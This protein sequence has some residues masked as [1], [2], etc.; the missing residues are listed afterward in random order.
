M[1]TWDPDQYLRFAEERARP[2]FDLLHQVPLTEATA[3]A[4]LGCGPGGLSAAL[5]ERFPSARVV[6]I[7]LD[8]E[9]IAHARRR[10]LPGRLTFEQ[11]DLRVWRSPAPLDLAFSNA[12]LHWVAD[13]PAVLDHLTSQLAPGGV[14]AFQ[15][16]NNFEEP[17]HLQLQRL[18][19]TE[20]WRAFAPRL[21][22]AVHEATWYVQQLSQRGFAVNAWET[23]Y[24][25]V[26]SG[27][28]AITEW[29]AGST[30]RPILA[31]LD[32]GQQQ[33]FCNALSDRLE[34]AYPRRSFGT[35]FPFRRIFVVAHDRH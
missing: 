16:P 13:H 6:G 19:Q 7:D 25:Q 9:M 26:L 18:L 24:L 31:A 34:A 21:Q 1:T 32:E 17:S 14:L 8:R 20:E 28:E 15:V 3:V 11:A 23:T 10:E 35:I 33:A 29:M 27:P 12:S 22:A 5:A 30:L 4:D 2:F